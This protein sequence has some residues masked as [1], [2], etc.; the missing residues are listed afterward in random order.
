M[1][2]ALPVLLLLAAQSAEES[3]VVRDAMFYVQE[4]EGGQPATRRTI[5]VPLRTGQCYGWALRVEPEERTVSI[6]EVFELPAPGNWNVGDQMSAVARNART[7]VT[8]FEAPLSE[9]VITHGWC[10]AEGD[11]AGPHR[12]RVYHGETLLRD[13]R[14]TVTAETR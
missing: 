5:V 14:F 7:A 2:A 12:I 11:P 6:R 9:G 13:F 1:N 3:P 4:N 8:Q 10:V